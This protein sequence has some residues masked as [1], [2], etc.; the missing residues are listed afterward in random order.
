MTVAPNAKLRFH[1][2]TIFTDQSR[3]SVTVC[4][5]RFGK[6]T[7]LLYKLFQ[8][9]CEQR[10]LYGYFAPTYKQAKLIA[11]KI[12]KTIIPQNYM[13][14]KPNESELYV[15]LRNGSEIR[16]FGMQ[17]A[18][19][20]FG[21]KLHGGICDEYDQMDKEKVKNVL[22]PAVSDT[23]G[24]IWYC[25]TPDA[26]RGQIKELYETVRHEKKEGKR[27]SWNT[28]RYTSLQGGYI[29]AS[30]ID[31]AREELDERT[32][33]QNYE[34]TFETA[35]GKVYYAFDFDEHVD[36]R[37][38][39]NPVLP[40]RMY[41]DFNVDPFVVGLAHSFDRVSETKKTYQDIHCFDEFTIRNFN[42]PAMCKEIYK[43]YGTHVNGIY[44][45][46]DASSR[47]RH[48][49]SSVSD[50]T[51]IK[52]YF[53]KLPHVQLRFKEANPLVKDRT[54]SVNSKLRTIDGKIHTYIHPKCRSLIKD[55]M[56][57]GYKEGTTEIDK[58]NIELTHASDGFGYY[59]EYEMP[60]MKGFIN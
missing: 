55:L 2:G 34:A 49:S 1:Q 60:V 21:I 29:P 16:L 5:R 40:I 14:G 20:I 28:F 45:Y 24:F 39:Y 44:I 10:G 56:D 58:T 8:K 43:K 30:E 26:T 27:K 4:G 33:R 12:L 3:F 35:Q 57:V 7:T 11:W 25:G 31:E 22:R 53:S 15:R 41:W 46:G 38:K 18:E 19:N 47:N 50:Y 42:T 9:S 17:D 51:I 52:D 32:F 13:F 59:V 6:T 48:T 37:I 54:N 23:L 36:G